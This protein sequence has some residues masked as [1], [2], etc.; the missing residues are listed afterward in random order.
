MEITYIHDKTTGLCHVLG[1]DK[2]L[3]E[4]AYSEMKGK[5]IFDNQNLTY[6]RPAQRTEA[7]TKGEGKALL[8]LVLSIFAAYFILY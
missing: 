8:T 3:R 2:R 6:R 7:L 4:I 1:H 5:V